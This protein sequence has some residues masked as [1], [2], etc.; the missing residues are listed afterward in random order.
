MKWRGLGVFLLVALSLRASLVSKLKASIENLDKE[1]YLAL[2]ADPSMSGL[3]EIFRFKPIR[4]KILRQGNV[5]TIGILRKPFPLIEAW[6]IQEDG[7]RIVR[8]E[9]LFTIRANAYYGEE[10][11]RCYLLKQ[12]TVSLPDLKILFTG[13]KFCQWPDIFMFLGRGSFT[14]SPSDPAEA[15]ALRYQIGEEKLEERI[16]FLA[17]RIQHD[18]GASVKFTIGSEVPLGQRER[19]LFRKHLA[20]FGLYYSPLLEA[21]VLPS[22]PRAGAVALLG[23]GRLY[24]YIYDPSSEREI[25]LADLKAGKYLSLYSP[26]GKIMIILKPPSPEFLRI[27]GE[28]NTETG[29]VEAEAEVLFSE[30]VER[31]FY[32]Y[33][34]P[35]LKVGKVRDDRGLP[36]VFQKGSGGTY[37]IYPNGSLR[38]FR[39]KYS[40]EIKPIESYSSLAGGYFY[41]TSWYPSLNGFYRYSVRLKTRGGDLLVPG[42]RAGETYRSEVPV[43]YVG[44][45]FG[46][47]KGKFQWE[48]LEVF[49]E[50]KSL[51]DAYAVKRALERV[52][53]F[54]GPLPWKVK[55][56][57]ARGIFYFGAS[58]PGLVMLRIL[59]VDRNIYSPGPMPCG[60]KYLIYHEMVHQWVGGLISPTTFSDYWVNEGLTSLMAGML[61]CGGFEEKFRKTFIEDVTLPP[62]VMGGRIGYYRSS[63]RNV[64]AHL[65]Y[66]SALV[67]NM[68]RLAL[69]E[70]EFLNVVKE[71]LRE[72]R[73]REYRW[74]KFTSFLEKRMGRPGFFLPW[75]QT[76]F[77]PEFN[78]YYEDGVLVV[79]ERRALKIGDREVHFQIPV[80]VKTRG[81]RKILWVNGRGS[82]YVSGKF[83]IEDKVLPAVFHRSRK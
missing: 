55:V 51:K 50:R 7:E 31:K 75:V 10:D 43:P 78:Y 71:F 76:D 32:F 77:I 42:K 61:S 20:N 17:L 3:Q 37:E 23:G 29:T 39:I 4:V 5:L 68:A 38:G 66:R 16:S 59:P 21:E 49:W 69:G 9:V 53:K 36:V 22:V 60:K 28:L 25:Y 6:K 33:L 46:R 58:S 80:P 1:A 73:F 56:I 19:M 70:E 47:F 74:G 15:R 62:L 79:N 8:K 2:F 63:I 45:G 54:L 14:F 83:K 81:G 82:L 12:A 13:G 34:A 18:P 35:G 72:N 57:L 11:C 30:P 48:N 64:F 65:H 67:L 52:E 41:P 44:L 40:G 26:P 24:K 27:N